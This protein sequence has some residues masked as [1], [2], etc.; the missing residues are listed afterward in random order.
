VTEDAGLAAKGDVSAAGLAVI[1]ASSDDAII[2]KTL[3]GVMTSWNAGATVMYGYA[4]EEMLGHNIAELIPPDRAGELTPIL[5]RLGRGERIE[6]YETRRVRKD[7]TVLDV[8]VSISPILDAAGRVIGAAS[9]A[10][11]ISARLRAEAGQRVLEARLRQSERL[12]TVG[13]LASGVAHDFNN[14]LGVI[15]G[16]AGMLAEEVGDRPGVAEDVEQIM[17]AAQRAAG[18]T[19]Q[20]LIFSGRDTVQPQAVDINDVVADL[21]KLLQASLGSGVD[22]VVSQEALPTVQIDRGRVDQVLLN[23]AVNARDAMPGGGTLS[24]R[25]GVTD[26][27]AAY[28]AAHTAARP[29]SYV[30]LTVSDTGTGMSAEVAARAFEPFF[31]TKPFGEGTGLGLATVHGV[32]SHAGGSVSVESQVGVGTVFRC[33]FPPVAVPAAAG[34]PGAAARVLV[35]DDEP[36]VLAV[37]SRILRG[38]GFEVTQA[39]SGAEALALLESPEF[40]VDLLLTDLVMPQMSGAALVERAVKA[41]PGIRALHMSGFTPERLNR[42]GITGDDRAF[43]QK[44]FTGPALLQ[45]VHTLLGARSR[46]ADR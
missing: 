6:H 46:P 20:L 26:L 5:E 36:A 2:G 23:L 19:R 43:I 41:H 38:A 32:M 37:T 35:V 24:V 16:C 31:T 3:D 11:D 21:R 28:C 22:L 17:G 42:E 18:L 10:R 44:P 45:K 40:Q 27:D 14:L 1:V 39:S 13:Q 34:K 29:G 9:I 33:Y 4:A 25:T 15:V 7:G 30:V 8:S 12:E